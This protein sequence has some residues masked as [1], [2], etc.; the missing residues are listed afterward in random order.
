MVQTLAESVASAHF[1]YGKRLVHL[2]DSG[3]IS[4]DKG[5]KGNFHLLNLTSAPT[6]QFPV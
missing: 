1:P 3:D 5:K 2:A 4:R 6:K